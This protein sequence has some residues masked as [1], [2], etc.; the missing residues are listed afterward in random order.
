MISTARALAISLFLSAFQAGAATISYYVEVSVPSTAYNDVSGYQT[1]GPYTVPQLLSAV[2]GVALHDAS[3]G[4]AGTAS[5][6]K[7]NQFTA[8]GVG[9]HQRGVLTSVDFV[10]AWIARGAVDVINTRTSDQNFINAYSLVPLHFHPG[11]FLETTAEAA[12]GPYSGTV[13]K[14]TRQTLNLSSNGAAAASICSSL[15]G[16]FNN[17]TKICTNALINGSTSVGGT[18]T[19]SGVQTGP[20]VSSLLDTLYGTGNSTY[21]VPV[22]AEQGVYSGQAASGVFFG[23]SA[24]AG[25]L[26]SITYHYDVVDSPAPEP[27]TLAITGGAL[28]GLIV[29]RQ[30]RRRSLANAE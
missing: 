4:F 2:Q 13:P 6:P 3:D 28:C 27:A 16:S 11:G 8:P 29:R 18:A 10:V 20:T 1:S 5:L 23:G 25:G 21:T 15:G 9:P 24:F 19:Y 26:A 22:I 7:F 12:A 14:A 30:K 17:T